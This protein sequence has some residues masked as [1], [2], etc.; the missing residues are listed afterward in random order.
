MTACGRVLAD[1]VSH[2][3]RSLRTRVVGVM[4]YLLPLLALALLATVFLWNK[5][6]EAGIGLTFSQADIET[7]RS[8][9]RVTGPQLSGSSLNGDI[10]DFRAD[11]VIPQDL[12]LTHADI[13]GLTGR[14]LF[15]DGRQ[16]D[17]SAARAEIEMPS[18][19]VVLDT[20]IQIRTSDGYE[21]TAAR[22]EVDLRQA[23]LT[24][25]GPVVASG[26]PGRIAAD[27]MIITPAS[28]DGALTA[29]DTLIRFTGG[30]TLR[31]TPR[32]QEE[33]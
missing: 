6:D 13:E 15:R 24:A 29:N 4:K 22:A 16:V 18:Q 25:T 3:R 26:P 8:G 21:A 11:V 14:I 27:G 10:Y 2:P 33:R 9:L 32:T 17:L 23:V 19:R 12:Q 1:P 30:V 31:Y 20:G 28:A 5:D 7:M